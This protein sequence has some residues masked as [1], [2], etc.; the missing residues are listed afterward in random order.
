MD[1]HLDKPGVEKPGVEHPVATLAFYGPDDVTVTKVVLGIFESPGSEP[2]LRRWVGKGILSRPKFSQ[3][4]DEC[5]RKHGVKRTIVHEA[6]LGCPHEEGEDFPIG[7][8]CP[9]CPFWKGKT[10][11]ISSR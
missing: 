6:S 4:F 8:D 3:Q 1:S 2:I 9:F 11:S 7:G 10:R 5:L